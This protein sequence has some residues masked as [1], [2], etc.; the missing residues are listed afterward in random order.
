MHVESTAIPQAFCIISQQSEIRKTN[1]KASAA[2]WTEGSWFSMFPCRDAGRLA[3]GPTCLVAE[4]HRQ[5]AGAV[6][7][8]EGHGSERASEREREGEADLVRLRLVSAEVLGPQQVY[9]I[10]CSLPHLVPPH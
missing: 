2:R 6:G 4:W 5:D 8:E 3:E 1:R 9:L 7:R 10:D